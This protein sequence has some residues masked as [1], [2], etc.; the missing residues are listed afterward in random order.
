MKKNNKL[1]MWI[2]FLLS[3]LFMG[4]LIILVGYY[5]DDYINLIHNDTLSGI[6][7]LMFNFFYVIG[8]LPISVLGLITSTLCNKFADL[9]KIKAIL[10]IESAVFI[11]GIVFTGILYF[12]KINM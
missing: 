4:L 10:Y 3:V 12:Y 8:F 7:H 11:L 5:I 2:F 1:L 6:D 9:K